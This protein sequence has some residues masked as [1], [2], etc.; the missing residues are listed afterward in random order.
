[1][2][3]KNGT[4]HVLFRCRYC[5]GRYFLNYGA[6]NTIEDMKALYPEDRD[7]KW[8]PLCGQGKSELLNIA[9]VVSFSHLHESDS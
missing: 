2:M 5:A 8:C 4:W 9:F 1:M 6:S 3:P 7:E